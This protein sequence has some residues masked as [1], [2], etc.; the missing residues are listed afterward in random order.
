M[1]VIKVGHGGSATIIP[2]LERW[3]QVDPWGWWLA[4]H[5]YLVKARLLRNSVSKKEKKRENDVE[6][7][8]LRLFSDLYTQLCTHT[9]SHVN[10]HTQMHT[11]TYAHEHTYTVKSFLFPNC[12]TSC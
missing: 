9:L 2:A 6:G 7:Q 10:T 5:G 3:G 12:Q 1:H 4:G 11:C 8:H